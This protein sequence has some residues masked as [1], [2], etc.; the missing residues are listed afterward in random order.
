[1]AVEKTGAM[2]DEDSG[3]VFADSFRV[4][5]RAHPSLG[6]GVDLVPPVASQTS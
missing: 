2:D 1:M 3:R 5:C 6:G 4:L